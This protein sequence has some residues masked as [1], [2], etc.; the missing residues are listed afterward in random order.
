MTNGMFYRNAVAR[1]TAF[2]FFCDNHVC[3]D[4]SCKVLAETSLHGCLDWT[5][6]VQEKGWCEMSG[7]DVFMIGLEKCVEVTVLV[8]AVVAFLALIYGVFVEK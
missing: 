5:G 2:R 7:I 1:K 6:Q 3:D 8:I 4:R